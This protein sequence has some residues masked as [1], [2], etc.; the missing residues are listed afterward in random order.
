MLTS[1]GELD[2]VKIGRIHLHESG[3]EGPLEL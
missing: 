2:V 3:K 1:R